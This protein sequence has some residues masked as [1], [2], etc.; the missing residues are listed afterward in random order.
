MFTIKRAAAATGVR[1]ATLRAWE[2]R[3]AVVEPH[4]TRAGYRLYDDE[5]LEVL[6]R[7]RDLV[8]Q[9]WSPREAVSE[10]QRAVGAAPRV[11]PQSPAGP[12]PRPLSPE[13]SS[14][15]PGGGDEVWPGSW[16]DLVSAAAA[17]DPDLARHA[18]DEA[19]A[20]GTFES[21]VQA[22]LLPAL[23]DLGDAWADGRVSVAGEHLVSSAVHRRLS[24]AF[25]AAGDPRGAG[26][27]VVGL[28]P[29]A[30]HELGLL[31]FA[32]AARRT[33][34]AVTYLGADLP[35]REWVAAGRNAGAAVVAVPQ[36]EDVGEARRVVATL[37]RGTPAT[38][39]AAGGSCQERMPA[40]CVRLGHDVAAAAAELAR[41]LMA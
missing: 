19:F 11:E 2:R 28:P 35:A 37:R 30:R 16:P 18:L 31:A 13:P 41:L 5:Q 21:V 3:Y 39:V 36:P 15:A 24:A 22:W 33:G 26:R 10:A 20:R 6:R 7:M 8:A 9:G 40:S 29:G 27:V 1:E 25:E 14:S 32:T 23:T 34:L 17:L 12:S 38:L 4:R